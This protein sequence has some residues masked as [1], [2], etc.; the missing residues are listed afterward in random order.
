MNK[1]IIWLIVAIVVIAGIWWGVS[2]KPTK[3]EVIKIG[4]ILP[5]TGNVA[6]YGQSAKNA[7]ELAVNE[8][9][10]QGGIKGRLLQI[11]YEDGK[12]NGKEASTAAHKLIEV[13]KV[14]IILGGECS[15]EVLAE[16]PITEAN[17]VILFS[18]F[19][20]HPDITN[21]GDYVFRNMV[22]DLQGGRDAA[23]MIKEKKVAALVE[24][25]EYAQALEKVF[26]EE[27]EKLGKMI[28]AEE[29][30]NPGEKDFRSHLIKIKKK[31]PEA[32]FVNCQNVISGGLAVKQIRE[33]GLEIP[34]YSMIVF[35]G[36]DALSA[37][38]EA[39]DGVIFADAPGLNK[40]N[41]K[42][43][44][45]LNRYK[46][47]Y[48]EPANEYLVGAKYDAVYLIANALKKCNE[49]TDCIR[50]YLYGVEEYN[51]VIGKYR[52]DKNGD[53]EGLRYVIKKVVDGQ[54]I[55]IE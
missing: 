22:N 50:D 10:S 1:T 41:P 39:A 42:A 54:P 27:L 14:K 20:S 34:I 16:A 49:D 8:I 51:G 52:F 19:A 37:A 44:E 23:R 53:I 4:A 36:K 43:V 24:S 12:C 6:S 11:I 25:T 32:I 15:A 45:F 13:D 40:N 48:G 47:K 28:I 2:R 38:G 26:K 33:M 17:K 30:Y 46:E 18:S 31:K 29:N 55:E 5:L 35:S 7:I 3:E 21:A 9:N